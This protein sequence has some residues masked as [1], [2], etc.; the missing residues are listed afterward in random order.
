MKTTLVFLMSLLLSGCLTINLFQPPA[1]L[2]EKVLEGEGKDKI[3]LLNISGVISEEAPEGLVED[4]DMVARVKEELL[5]AEKDKSVK[6][7]LLNI[8][9]PGGTVTASDLIYHEI[10]QF[11]ARSGKKVTT[12]ISGLGASGA[13]YIAMASDRIMAHPTAVVGS[14]GVIMLNMNLQGLLEKIGVTA[15]TIKSGAQKDTGSP[16]RKMTQEDRDILQ[17]MIMSMQERFLEIVA[18]GRPKMS[19]EQIKDISDARVFTSAEAKRLNL[20]DQ[21]GY[22]DEAIVLAKKDVGLAE[23]KIISYRRPSQYVNNI[24]SR[25]SPRIDPLSAWKLDPK[26]LLKGRPSNFFYLWMP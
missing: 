10:M 3:L 14:V 9:S 8:N 19:P 20:I 23:A 11:K 7:I 24:Y 17:G 5:L 16:F 6:A 25:L 18:K 13:Y 12:S 22:L 26:D 21:I 4:P 1:P 2:E 15:E